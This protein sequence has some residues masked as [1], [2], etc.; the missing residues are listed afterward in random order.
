MKHLKI[1]TIN[2]WKCDGN[3]SARM[4]I[5]AKQ[6]Q[7]LKPDIIACQECFYSKKA[8][9]D[10]LKYLA[11]NLNM[12]YSFLPGR[13]KKRL[14]EEK[15]VDSLSGLGILSIFPIAAERHY[16][17]PVVPGDEDRKALQTEID[18]PG[19]TKLCLTNTHLTHLG[20]ASGLRTKQAGAVAGIASANTSC[21]YNL[22][23]GDFNSVIGS[24]EMIT[25]IR[26]ASAIDC[27]W[28]GNGTEPRYSMTDAYKNGKFYCVDHIFVLPYPGK[29]SYPEFIN[30]G[31]VLNIADEVTGLYPS[32]HFGISTTIVI[33]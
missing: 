5:L 29:N 20:N 18:L 24:E 9:A 12:N 14:F 30:S 25:F 10:T 6:L 16:D 33:D 32:D 26:S 15:W 23:C 11:E 28:A 13:F 4:Q 17:L 21:R 19:S 2:T 8:N 31:I 27:Y 22:V 1:I 3:Y 7:A